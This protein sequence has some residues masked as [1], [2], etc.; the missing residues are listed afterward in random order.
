MDLKSDKNG[1]SR[2]RNN[3]LKSR[4]CNRRLLNSADLIQLGSQNLVGITALT[5]FLAQEM[6]S[7]ILLGTFVLL[8]GALYGLWQHRF[9]RSP[10]YP[11]V[12]LA[13]LRALASPA[14]GVDWLGPEADPRLR[15]RVDSAHSKVVAR[16]DLPW[17]KPV[18]FL[19]VRFH[20]SATNLRAGDEIWQD[21]RCLIEWHSQAGGSTWENNPFRSAK[22]H[23]NSGV[24]E[25]VLRPD[26]PPAIPAL[27]LENLGTSGDL[28]LFKFEASVLRERWIWKIGR[29]LLMAG[30]LAWIVAWIRPSC[31][32]GRARSLLASTI[33]LVM[34]L[35][36]VVPGPWKD[37]RSLTRPFEI[38]PESTLVTGFAAP[39]SRAMLPP[40]ARS[41]AS[42][43]ALESVG[44]I[45]DQGDFTLRLKHYAA[46]ARPLLHII[47]LFAPAL[48]IACL[49]GR[50]P[51]ISLSIL[52]AFS[53]E[54]AQVLFGFGFDWI[55]V[56][57]LASD[58]FGIGLAC[59]AHT[60]LKRKFPLEVAS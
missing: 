18:N 10:E 2:P 39:V 17:N 32:F 57:D 50:N 30:W 36:F 46:K 15:L 21:G 49:V 29:W 38:P 47:L 35:Y 41:A 11:T 12:R 19:H 45:P 60:S 1:S 25:M 5:W 55:D 40:M 20:L 27:R 24:V 54:T 14:P 6:R 37:V 42:P 43:A 3:H 9:E 28:E 51:A 56:L 8:L 53:I 16:V 23:E 13:D 59:I 48:A 52:L 4:L 58:A 34:A 33:W 44:K 22:N 26:H 7:L 31:K